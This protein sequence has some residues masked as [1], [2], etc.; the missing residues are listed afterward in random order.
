MKMLY[1]KFLILFLLSSIS[2][3]FQAQEAG[4]EPRDFY[5][6]IEPFLV[7]SG[8]KGV[9]IQAGINE[10]ISYQLYGAW[11]SWWWQKNHVKQWNWGYLSDYIL[12][13]KGP[14][15]RMGSQIV[16]KNNPF[17]IA[18]L[19]LMPEFTYKHLTYNGKCFQEGGGSSYS[20]TRLQSFKSDV[21]GLDFQLVYRY[22]D[23]SEWDLPVE[24]FFGP[25]L[26][27]A[28]EEKHLLGQDTGI[29][30]SQEFDIKT[31][32]TSFYPTVRFGV[33]VGIKIAGKD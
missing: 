9:H 2:H 4:Y 22:C 5:I 10:K 14:V 15:L 7:L 11:Y 13:A 27:L 26:L 12:A 25:G 6:G 30:P 21:A 19:I 24:W 33:R 31:T 17:K 32:K 18:R 3:S 16:L 29:C 8:E 20:P 1:P 28:L 23:S